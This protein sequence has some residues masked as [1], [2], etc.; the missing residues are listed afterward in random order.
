MQF[1]SEAKRL[2][3]SAR[4]ERNPYDAFSAGFELNRWA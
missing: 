4:D 1:E 2:D 3:L